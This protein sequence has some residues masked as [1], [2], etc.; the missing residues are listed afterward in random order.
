MLVEGEGVYDWR[1]VPEEVEVDMMF[2]VFTS[3][4]RGVVRPI[5]PLEILET[6]PSLRCIRLTNFSNFIYLQVF[7]ISSQE[8]KS[9]V[10]TI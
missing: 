10:S 4:S 3:L 9:I 5:L 8:E 1:Y 2:V 6:L 7:C